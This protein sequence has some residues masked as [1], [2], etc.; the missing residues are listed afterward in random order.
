M[1]DIGQEN[2][3]E[4]LAEFVRNRF[5]GKYKGTVA[6]VGEGSELGLITA[7]VPAVYGDNESP[8]ALPSV[9]FAGDAHGFVTLPENGDGVWIE[10]EG[11]D[12]G[13]PIWTGFWWA[14]G[15]IP[16]EVTPKKR[17]LITPKGH[18]LIFDDDA[19]SITLAHA[20]GAEI[21]LTGDA[22][23]IKI[24]SSQIELSSSG[25]NCNNGALEVK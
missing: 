15:E 2:L 4:E 18:K 19:G 3:I 25:I 14:S 9:V 22:I 8:L 12:P 16:G 1:E 13:R 6:R 17:A 5:W 23:T 11:G 20:D 21:S 7:K 24:G 10:F